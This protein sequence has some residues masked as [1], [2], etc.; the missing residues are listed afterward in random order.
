MH[1]LSLARPQLAGARGGQC[2]PDCCLLFIRTLIQLL[3]Q[4]WPSDPEHWRHTVGCSSVSQH[5]DRCTT[6]VL[7]HCRFECQ[8]GVTVTWGPVLDC[9]Y[10]P[11]L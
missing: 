4:R 2:P 9:A 5:L 7:V 1:D 3:V 6:A 10:L 11:E 8:A